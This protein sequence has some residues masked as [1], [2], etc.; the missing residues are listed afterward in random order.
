V[1]LFQLEG[2]SNEETVFERVRFREKGC[3]CSYVVCYDTKSLLIFRARLKPPTVVFSE[4]KPHHV[5]ISR[6]NCNG[7]IT[8]GREDD[9]LWSLAFGKIYELC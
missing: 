2:S 6:W 9:S 4:N 7:S 8:L 3:G 1:A 5:Q